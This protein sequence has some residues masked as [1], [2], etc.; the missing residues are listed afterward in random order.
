LGI[1]LESGSGFAMLACAHRE[2]AQRARHAR[3]HLR[4]VAVLERC[5]DE[6]CDAYERGDP[7]LVALVDREIRQR[8]HHAGLHL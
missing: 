1:G 6:R 5:V 8:A 2:V 7:R 3:L 4:R